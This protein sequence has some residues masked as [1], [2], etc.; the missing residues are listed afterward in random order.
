MSELKKAAP[1]LFI[2]S[3][4]LCTM[5]AMRGGMFVAAGSTTID[6][7]PGGHPTI[8][9]AI[10]NASSGDL[11]SVHEG[12]YYEDIVVNK[13]V[14]LVG[15]DRDLTVIYGNE[16]QYVIWAMAGSVNVKDLTVRKNPSNRYGNVILVGF[17]SVGNVISHNRIENGYYGLVISSSYNN[18][19]SDNLISN[20]TNGLNLYYSSNNVFSDNVIA[21]NDLGIGLYFSDG[22]VFS[23]NTVYNNAN[24]LTLYSSVNK[25]VFYH[26]NFNNTLQ[27]WS[28][29]TNST[30]IWSINGEGNYWADYSGQDLNGDGI[31]NTPYPTDTQ[32]GD[33][34]PL[35]GQFYGLSVPLKNQSYDVDLI[36]NSSVSALLFEIGKE[37]GNRLISFNVSGSE[38]TLGF[39]RIMIP[40]GLMTPPFA[41]LSSEGEIT[42]TL[43]NA[44]N[45]TNAYLYFTWTHSSQIISIVSSETLH[46][47]DELL[48]KYASL[49]DDFNS[50]NVT[51]NYLLANYSTLIDSLGELQSKYLALNA[52]YYEHLLDY[53]R[54]VENT[55][56]LMYIFAATTAIFLATTVYLSKRAS[57]RVKQGKGSHKDKE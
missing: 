27:L 45:E 51:H 8:Q 26:N 4:L 16:A 9:E 53:S 38:G 20:S 37:T 28:D 55:R 52:S 36:S 13:S 17:G 1:I 29:S 42:P 11:I 54:N 7:F 12:T 47:Y 41:I 14:S 18:V 32:G 43:L 46:L 6:V 34:H 2:S 3:L 22:N 31:G 30:N 33:D 10:N 19:V 25:N 21:N 50:L 44:S 49:L 24:G 57:A 23:R 35:M 56:N 39:C 40:L 5:F 15:E 48:N